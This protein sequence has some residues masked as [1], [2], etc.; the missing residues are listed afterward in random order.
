MPK[1]FDKIILLGGVFLLCLIWA[2]YFLPPGDRIVTSFV[3]AVAVSGLLTLILGRKKKGKLTP[4]QYESINRITT[5]LAF[6]D[7]EYNLDFFGTALGKAYTVTKHD[8]YLIV[9]NKS[10]TTIVFPFLRLIKLTTADLSEMYANVRTIHRGSPLLI[11][12]IEGA[13]KSAGD[14]ASELSERH[15]TILDK[16]DIYTLLC[17]LDTFPNITVVVSKKR[18]RIGQVARAALAPDKAKRYLLISGFM[19]LTS[20]IVPMSIFYIVFAS[21]VTVVAIACKLDIVGLIEKKLPKKP[22]K[23]TV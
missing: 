21:L 14:T 19:L 16:T 22:S 11:L 4:K 7:L 1:I 12:T 9:A 23:P 18:K 17:E 20:L 8:T 13:T 6:S 3:I 15:V 10:K 2:G 5:Q